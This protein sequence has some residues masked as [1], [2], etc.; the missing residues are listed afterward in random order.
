V[1]G[2][3]A[4]EAR[5]HQVRGMTMVLWGL[6]GTLLA[7]LLGFVVYVMSSGSQG[8]MGSVIAQR[9][10]INMSIVPALLTLMGLWIA[11]GPSSGVTL[12]RWLRRV[13]MLV[14]V[15][16]VVLGA[17]RLVAHHPAMTML[18][19][20]TITTPTGPVSTTVFSKLSTSW[21]RSYGL[22]AIA[23]AASVLAAVWAAWMIR[24]S[25]AVGIMPR[26]RRLLP[27][28]VVAAVVV[29][30]AFAAPQ[31][32]DRIGRTTIP[33]IAG[34]SP[35]SLPRPAL[36][37]QAPAVRLSDPWYTEWVN[38]DSALFVAVIGYV[39]VMLLGVW[40][41]IGMLRLRERT[42]HLARCSGRT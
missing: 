31:V 40:L 13:L 33:A 19:G 21:I 35:I 26:S 38:P 20:R 10:A 42:M 17:Q 3:E 14:F 41:W 29:L 11:V 34:Y 39:L 15:L 18:G 1:F 8:P 32:I 6:P 36:P 25:V 9:A 30:S 37:G 24:A 23:G 7:C 12:S 27:T 28:A 5:A 22:G 4:A 2:F 16:V